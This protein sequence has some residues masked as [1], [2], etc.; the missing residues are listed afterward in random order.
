MVNADS[1]F[2]VCCP[3]ASVR[4][5]NPPTTTTTTTTTTESSTQGGVMG[6]SVGADSDL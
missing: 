3:E 2:Q 5:A 4:Q 6:A 1:R